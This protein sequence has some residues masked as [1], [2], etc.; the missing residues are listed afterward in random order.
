MSLYQQGGANQL[1][2]SAPNLSLLDQTDLLGNPLDLDMSLPMDLDMDLMGAGADQVP[3][4]S[5][6]V[7]VNNAVSS[8]PL[9]PELLG[10][11]ATGIN[12]GYGESSGEIFPFRS[13]PRAW[14]SVPPA[15][16]M[17]FWR[18]SQESA[19]ASRTTP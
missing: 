4:T 6:G 3:F 7:P 18:T 9:D 14:A 5:T 15:R 17:A 2:G 1:P 19:A 16:M 12:N 10:T 11:T 13:E 8:Q